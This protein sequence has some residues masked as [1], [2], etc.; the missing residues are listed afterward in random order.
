MQIVVSNRKDLVTTFRDIMKGNTYATRKPPIGRISRL[1][2]LV[3]ARR[4]MS[5]L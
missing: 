5:P 4:F 3:M 1:S 2:E